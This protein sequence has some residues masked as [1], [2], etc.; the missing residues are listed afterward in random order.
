MRLG[1]VGDVDFGAAPV[2]WPVLCHILVCT[3]WLAVLAPAVSA[4]DAPEFYVPHNHNGPRSS[5]ARQ[6]N[7]ALY[8]PFAAPESRFQA[9][10]SHLNSQGSGNQNALRLRA[11]TQADGSNHPPHH[12]RNQVYTTATL[13][14]LT[15]SQSDTEPTPEHSNPH[16]RT[17]DPPDTV[18]ADDNDT[19]DESLGLDN[20]INTLT[21]RTPE[22]HPDPCQFVKDNCQSDG[23]IDYLPLYYCR[24]P[25]QPGVFYVVAVILLVIYFYVLYHI[26][27]M[28]LTGA[29][30]QLS[31]YLNMSNEVAGLTL[32]SFGNSAPD[33][34]TALAGVSSDGI[35]L[36][37]GSTLSGGIFVITFV[38]G[39]VI[40]AADTYYRQNIAPRQSNST[41]PKSQSSQ[42]TREANPHTPWIYS[43]FSRRAFHRVK[44]RLRVLT[45]PLRQGTEI[46]RRQ[47]QRSHLF[48][49][50]SAYSPT[51]PDF[52]QLSHAS[53]PHALD[54]KQPSLYGQ[55]LAVKSNNALDEAGLPL[56]S[57]ATTE[58]FHGYPVPPFH[59]LRNTLV[60]GAAVIVL[61]YSLANNRFNI[62]ETVILF[63]GYILFLASYFVH[64]LVKLY[65]RARTKR[66]K[67]A[68]SATMAKPE[69][70]LTP[71]SDPESMIPH[72][73][74]DHYQRQPPPLSPKPATLASAHTP[75]I[76][77]TVMTDQ[78]LAYSRSYLENQIMPTVNFSTSWRYLVEDYATAVSDLWPQ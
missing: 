63:G 1:R 34:F 55:H 3:A 64:Y 31:N 62:Y 43:L 20:A 15:R 24:W 46:E 30:Q 52:A 76:V 18:A 37:L 40:I 74:K 71:N 53:N 44:R 70:P 23:L 6:R 72:Y 54:D 48:R 11:A 69:H 26:S 73:P 27:D 39:A 68:A 9:H 51:M 32:L 36:V 60:Y 59:W 56:P 33:F 45:R 5:S 12:L 57:V 8:Y 4:A 35:E 14:P 2:L 10:S 78:Q 29:L 41:S 58:P 50:T 67:A 61:T 17:G 28:Y 65:W 19:V 13:A 38:L 7:A 16:L 25:G 66:K 42:L 75:S 47:I 49:T 22:L 21:C 77:P